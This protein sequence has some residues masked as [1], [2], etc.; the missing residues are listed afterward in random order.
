MLL[1]GRPSRTAGARRCL[2]S[3]SSLFTLGFD[4]PTGLGSAFIAFTEAAIGLGA[5]RRVDRVPAHDL[6]LVLAARGDGHA[7]LGAGRNAAHRV[8]HARARA[9]RRVPQRSRPGVERVDAVVLASCRRPTPRSARSRSSARRTRTGRGSPP[10]APCSTR[11][12]LRLAVLNIPFTP[13]PGLCIRSGFL[14]LREIADFFGFD[15]DADPAPDD[16]ISVAHEE[17]IEIY[18]RLAGAGLPVRP[19]RERAWRDFAGWRVNYDRVL[20]A[21]CTPG[22]GA[23]RAVVVG[24]IA[25]LAAPQPTVGST[26][27]PRRPGRARI[28]LYRSGQDPVISRR[29]PHLARIIPVRAGR[30]RVLAGGRGVEAAGV[31]RFS[32]DRAR[33]RLRR[34]RDGRVGRLPLP[35]DAQHDHCLLPDERLV[36]GSAAVHRLPA[37]RAVPSQ[38]GVAPVAAEHVVARPVERHRGLLRQRSRAVQRLRLCGAPGEHQRV[39]DR[40]VHM[41]ADGRPRRTEGLAGRNG[42]PGAKGAPGKPGQKGPA[43]P[44]VTVPVPAAPI[45]GPQG[46]SGATGPT[47]AQGPQG[48]VGDPGLNGQPGPPGPSI[49]L[50]TPDQLIAT[51]R[52]DLARSSTASLPFNSGP[53]GVAY[54]GNDVWVANFNASTVTKIDPSDMNIVASVSLPP[55]SGPVGRGVRRDEHLGRRTTRAARCR[56]STPAT[57]A[58]TGTVSLPPGSGPIGLAFDGANLWVSNNT[59]DTVSRVDVGR[60]AVTAVVHAAAQLGAVGTRV[61]RIRHLGDRPRRQHGVAHRPRLDG[62]ERD[63]GA[64]RRRG[65]LRRRL[66]PARASGSR[67]HDAD[68]MSKIDPVTGHDHGDRGAAGR[69]RSLRRGLRRAGSCGSPTPRRAPSRRSSR[70]RPPRSAPARCRSNSFSEAIAFDGTDLWVTNAFSS[71]VTRVRPY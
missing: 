33:R 29:T 16:P 44:L 25:A 61:R 19:D 55:N 52:W 23:V 2:T 39:A 1:R 9:P 54:D 17:F 64:A 26:P 65:A 48:N 57:A 6:R 13:E 69:R 63:G 46:P 36:E 47:G 41:G 11:P 51:L 40:H 10:R 49:G 35:P 56:R 28:A 37:R 24:P 15:H 31:A 7:A 38:R 5:P 32:R 45:P 18:E 67:N 59:T 21:L 30:S 27:A 71:T 62:G 8:A 4:R 20:L 68:S 70:S 22:D 60:G 43:A 53:D 58:I 14:A 50:E 3:G 66:R 42:A 34:R 12:A